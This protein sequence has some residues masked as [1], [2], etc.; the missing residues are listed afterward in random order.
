MVVHLRRRIA[1]QLAEQRA[2]GVQFDKRELDRLVDRQR[3]AE[4]GPLTCVLH[5]S[6]DAELRR[7]EAR[8]R[9]ADPVL[10]HEQ[11]RRGESLALTTNDR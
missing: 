10:V 3:L 2:I 8:S 1:D 6:I 4:D 5:A 11:H 9:L 7:A